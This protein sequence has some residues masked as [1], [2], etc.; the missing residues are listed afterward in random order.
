VKQN[1]KDPEVKKHLLVWKRYKMNNGKGTATAK[2][3]PRPILVLTDRL[4]P[5]ITLQHDAGSIRYTGE[6]DKYDWDHP[7]YWVSQMSEKNWFPH[8]TYTGEPVSETTLMAV[9]MAV[10]AV[11]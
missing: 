4:V 11:G 10:A 1:L 3:L 2:T 6:Q 7:L 5:K 8:P 9:T